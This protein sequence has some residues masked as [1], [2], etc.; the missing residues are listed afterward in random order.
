MTSRV[1][2]TNPK[3]LI[4]IEKLINLTT[5]IFKTWFHQMILLKEFK[6]KP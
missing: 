6:S 5:L 2:E 4:I 3:A 1:K